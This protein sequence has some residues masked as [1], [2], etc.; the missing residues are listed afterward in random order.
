MSD[1]TS[2]ITEHA[3][4][5]ETQRI[6]IIYRK[7]LANKP[8]PRVPVEKGGPKP[9]PYVFYAR[10]E[11]PD[12]LPS[13]QTYYD[14]LCTL[15]HMTVWKAFLGLRDNITAGTVSREAADAVLNRTEELVKLVQQEAAQ[16][17][18]SSSSAAA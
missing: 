15:P 10:G 14:K 18:S 2:A 5:A 1:D 16:K 17:R 13:Y 8:V 3:Y 11:G 12:A 6:G 7:A 9:T 4:K